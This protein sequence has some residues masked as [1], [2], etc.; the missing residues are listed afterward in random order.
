MRWTTDGNADLAGPATFPVP[1]N[2]RPLPFPW[3]LLGWMSTAF[4]HCCPPLPPFSPSLSLPLPL[5]LPPP[6]KGKRTRPS[7]G[8]ARPLAP[9]QPVALPASF[10]R[11][12]GS[13]MP[14]AS[15]HSGSRRQQPQRRTGSGQPSAA[16]RKEEARTSPGRPLTGFSR[17]GSHPPRSMVGGWSGGVAWGRTGGIEGE[18]MGDGGRGMRGGFHTSKR[19][20]VGFA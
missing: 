14:A 1:R 7:Q 19:L 13:R 12:R 3:A 9:P 18:G 4:C 16:Q 10:S 11:K 17:G 20:P 6:T 8:L 2:R 5:P 15:N